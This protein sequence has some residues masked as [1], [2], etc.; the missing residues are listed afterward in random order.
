MGKSVYASVKAYSKKGKLLAR[1]DFQTLA[2]S[3]DLD[4]LMTRIKNTTYA[5]AVSE[6]QKPYTSQGIESA[7][8]GPP[9][10]GAPLH[11]ADGG[12]ELAPA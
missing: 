8:E 3:R 11:R 9:G 6:V 5:D 2:E 1:S 4:E 7:L 10:R 12:G